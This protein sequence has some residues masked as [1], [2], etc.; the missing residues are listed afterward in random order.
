VEAGLLWRSSSTPPERGKPVNP[1]TRASDQ[2]MKVARQAALLSY[3]ARGRKPWTAGYGEYRRRLLR[4]ILADEDLQRRFR[5]SAALPSGHGARVDARMVE[6]PWAVA[7]IA[8]DDAKLLDAGSSL[9]H[10]VVLE[11]PLMRRK[12]VTIMT[13]APEP[14]CYCSAGVSYC[15]GDLR[16]T[17][18]RD[19]YFDEIV[20]ISTLEHIG[21]DN[22]M[23]GGTREH[24]REAVLEVVDELRRLVR[25]GGLV[26]VTLPFGRFEDHGWFQ[27][28]DSAMV[29]RLTDRFN[30]ASVA[31][32]VYRYQISGWQVSNRNE[33]SECSFFDLHERTSAG[34]PVE[35]APDYAAG[36]RA[37]IC[38]EM[39]K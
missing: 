38:L 39:R 37:V 20:C 16:E 25:P 11:A 5:E 33:S 27:Q 36:E 18:Y 29:D 19:G 9:N 28:F 17:P 10:R 34:L 21:M 6:I 13:L 7:R 31:E 26:L 4:K 12:K 30:P 1:F 22:S 23:Y 24:D 35:L 14:E 8:D 2:L 15:Y 3:L 32:T